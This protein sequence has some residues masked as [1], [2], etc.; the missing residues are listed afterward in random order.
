MSKNNDHMPMVYLVVAI[1]C[2]LMVAFVYATGG[3]VW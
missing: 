3:L 1:M 2:G